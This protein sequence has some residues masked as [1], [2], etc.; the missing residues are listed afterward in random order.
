VESPALARAR[1]LWSDF[2]QRGVDGLLEHVGEDAV[3]VPVTG[4]GRTLRG[5]G[6]IRAWFVRQRAVHRDIESVVYDV[7]EHE[8]GCLL[9]HGGL[10][11]TT[12]TGLSDT[13]VYWV[14]QVRDDVVVR[15]EGHSTRARAL[16]SVTGVA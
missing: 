11:I 12:P 1:R 9:V 7:E 16:A 15:I 6:E 5:H 13:Q 4:G 2:S 8:G 10:R 14:L 3:L